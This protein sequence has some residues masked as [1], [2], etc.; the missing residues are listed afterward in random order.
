MR[1]LNFIVNGQSLEKDESCDFSDIIKGSHDYLRCVFKFSEDW[2]DYSKAIEFIT[3]DNSYF[4]MLDKDDSIK[5]PD[6]ATSEWYFK[7]KLYAT[8]GKNMI[9]PTNT[10]V[11][12]QKG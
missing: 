2:K 4:F 3:R 1:D 9:F 6:T 8:D 10:V 11:V 12:K 7:I 5:V